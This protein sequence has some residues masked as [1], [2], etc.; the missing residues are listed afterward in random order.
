MHPLDYSHYG[1]YACS[2][3]F[4]DPDSVSVSSQCETQVRTACIWLLHAGYRLYQNCE[5]SRPLQLFEE[6]PLSVRVR[7]FDQLR[8][9][10]WKEGLVVAQTVW[11]N[12]STRDLIRRAL[13]EIDR[14]E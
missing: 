7:G 14:V 3:A 8:W 1:L 2:E 9:R 5:H 13:G 11:R 12:P 4:E 6:G 10:V